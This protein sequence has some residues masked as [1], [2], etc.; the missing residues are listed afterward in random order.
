MPDSEELTAVGMGKNWI[1]GT[2][3]LHRVRLYSLSGVQYFIYDLP[4]Q[5]V[6]VAGF[7]NMLFVTYHYGLG[8]K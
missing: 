5:V 7:M 1:V 3:N 8:K 2:T 4:G 6:A